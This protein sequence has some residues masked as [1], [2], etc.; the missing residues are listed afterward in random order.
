MLKLRDNSIARDCIHAWE[1]FLD[2]IV[3][4]MIGGL[5]QL[6]KID[7]IHGLFVQ[8]SDTIT[9]KNGWGRKGLVW[10]HL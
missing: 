3:I 6:R 10:T 2:A 7:W 5:V 8:L 1:H 4:E 9:Y